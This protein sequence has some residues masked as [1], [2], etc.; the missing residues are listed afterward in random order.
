MSTARYI[1]P[2]ERTRLLA[3]MPNPRDRLLVILGLNTGFRVSELLSL[4][5]R[6]LW[7]DGQPLAYV[8]VARR[9]LKGGRSEWRKKVLSRRLPINAAATKAIREYVF[10]IS[11]SG[12]P[13]PAAW[14]FASRKRYPGVITRRQ[15]HTLI[16]RAGRR[17]G[18]AETVAP[19]GMRRA[20]GID[21]FEL[22][23]DVLLVRDL[24]GHRSVLTTE[25][26][27]R[28]GEDRMHAVVHQ[29]G[30]LAQ[31]PL[32]HGEARNFIA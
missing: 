22:T 18:L 12:C 23:K 17:A 24:L 11:G 8:E 32:A 10:A 6:Q 30:T 16:A 5:W 13:D 9:H 1:A 29:L 19:H 3:V 14:V 25:A 20:F 4:R 28:R 31:P 27:L 26:Y 15:A 2:E 7:Q 21:A